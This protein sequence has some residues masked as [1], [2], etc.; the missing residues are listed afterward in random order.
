M[1]ASD[2][3][4]ITVRPASDFYLPSS[5]RWRCAFCKK[6]ARLVIKRVHIRK[7]TLLCDAEECLNKALE[8][9]TT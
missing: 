8:G 9:E 6:R 7:Y 2:L 3:V 5:K 4:G 1:K